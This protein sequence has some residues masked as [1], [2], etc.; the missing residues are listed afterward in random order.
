MVKWLEEITVTPAESDNFYHFHDN[1]VLPPGIDQERAKAEG[2][3]R[4]RAPAGCCRRQL[5][6]GA[7][8]RG[9]PSDVKRGTCDMCSKILQ[10]I[11]VVGSKTYRPAW[12]SEQ[13]LAGLPAC[14]LTGQ[15]AYSQCVKE[16]RL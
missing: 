4:A 12:Q 3:P 15:L 6:L 16:S 7:R 1:R 13:H 2:A 9:K 11:N 14:A 5:V 8:A 10:D